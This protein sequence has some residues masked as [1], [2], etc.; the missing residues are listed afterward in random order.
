MMRFIDYTRYSREN[1]SPGWWNHISYNSD[2]TRATKDKDGRTAPFKIGERVICIHP[3]YATIQKGETLW[4][5]DCYVCYKGHWIIRLKRSPIGSTTGCAY[6]ARRF[7]SVE[8]E[9]TIQKQEKDYNMSKYHIAMKQKTDIDGVPIKDQLR[10]DDLISCDN[11][12]DLKREVEK[13]IANNPCERWVIFASTT[14][15]KA[16]SNVSFDSI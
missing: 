16:R 13:R 8:N 7:R 2:G 11:A 3:K 10:G 5:A 6:Y 4:V 14:I 12:H 9:P 15:A 1:K